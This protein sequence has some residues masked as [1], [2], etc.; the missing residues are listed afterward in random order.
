MGKWPR[1]D[2]SHCSCYVYTLFPEDVMRLPENHKYHA[3]NSGAK[4]PKLQRFAK[5]CTSGGWNVSTEENGTLTQNTH[6]N[7]LSCALQLW[8]TEL[9]DDILR[10]SSLLK[11]CGLTRPRPLHLPHTLDSVIVAPARIDSR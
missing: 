10:R 2:T 6:G 9:S 5:R 7:F 11:C 3:A 1:G 4:D 8:H